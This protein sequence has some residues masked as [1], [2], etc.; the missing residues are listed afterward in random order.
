MA[1][2]NHGDASH[3]Y[4]APRYTGAPVVI[5][6]GAGANVSHPTALAAGQYRLL[7]N[8]TAHIVQC[9]SNAIVVTAANGHPLAP[10]VP[11]LLNVTSADDDYVVAFMPAAG[12][13]WLSRR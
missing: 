1:Q 9:A 4:V 12:S 3:S 2:V 13:L 6:C 5:A 8:V 11:E 7:A 10:N